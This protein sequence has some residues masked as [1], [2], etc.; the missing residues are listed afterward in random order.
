[1]EKV[2]NF[3]E[4]FIN[5][6]DDERVTV[7]KKM[8]Y[9]YRYYHINFIID[10]DEKF[11]TYRYRDS[12]EIIFD[13]RNGCI[14]IHGGEEAYPIVIEDKD[15]LEKWSNIIEEITTKDLEE[16]VIDIFEKSLSGCYNK[17]MYRELQM[18]K[19]FKEDESL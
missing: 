12:M 19:I 5:H 15:L 13:N 6:L 9:G 11:Q 3:L 17:D 18:K 2:D 1:M 8:K 7:Y 4:F 14:E 10:S 16:R